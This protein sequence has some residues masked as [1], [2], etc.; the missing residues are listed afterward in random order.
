M[1]ASWCGPAGAPSGVREGDEGEM[2]DTAIELAGGSR[3]RLALQSAALL[4]AGLKVRAAGS[5][6]ANKGEMISDCCA[7][8]A[9]VWGLVVF[10]LLL[11]DERWRYTSSTGLKPVGVIAEGLPTIGLLALAT[12]LA[13]IGYRRLAGTA[14]I[15]GVGFLLAIW[16]TMPRWVL[17]HSSAVRDLHLVAV[18]GVPA[19]WYAVMVIAPGER[20]RHPPRLAW[21]L[22]AWLLGGI[23]AAP[24]APVDLF[25][26][27]GMLN[28]LLLLIAVA[29]AFSL[30]VD[31]WRSVAFALVLLAFGLASATTEA[32]PGPGFYGELHLALTTI[33]PLALIA[34]AATKLIAARRSLPS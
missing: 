28:V 9:T 29:G 14:G 19:I 18:C 15:A 4:C 30:T 24:N 3:W 2:R 6:P 5:P 27:I 22:V 23:F 16:L 26:S 12:G 13:L 20:L 31:I 25:A 17:P 32:F 33:V 34:G 11:G 10:T 21:L 1:E 7:R 8:A